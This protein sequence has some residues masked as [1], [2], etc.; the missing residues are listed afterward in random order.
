MSDDKDEKVTNTRTAMRA[1][2]KQLEYKCQAQEK[3]LE[4]LKQKVHNLQLR[5]FLI[6]KL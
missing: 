5:V 1:R 4:R 3:E 6:K 2:N